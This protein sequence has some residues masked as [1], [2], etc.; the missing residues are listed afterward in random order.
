MRGR[1][2]QLPLWGPRSDRLLACA[3]LAGAA[4][5]G[6]VAPSRVAIAIAVL[7]ILGLA[8]FV[9]MQS[10]RL[11]ILLLVA[12]LPV[13][14]VVW[15]ALYPTTGPA[16]LAKDFLF[17]IPAY[18]GFFGW[19]LTTKR[20]FAVPGLPL[21]PIGLLA[22]LVLIGLLNPSLPSMPVGL[23][24]VKVWLFYIP[25]IFLGYHLIRTRGDLDRLI[26]LMCLTAILP[27]VVGVVEAVLVYTGHANTVYSL[28]GAAASTVTQQYASVDVGGGT[29][30]RVPST[31]SFVAQYYIFMTVMVGIGY[32]WW[33]SATPGSGRRL[34]RFC[35]WLL[36]IVAVM[37][38]GARGALAF[39]PL[40]LVAILV[41]EG[42]VG[43]PSLR[44]L[45]ALAAG[46]LVM[47][48]LVGAN[49]VGAVGSLLDNARSQVHTVVISGATEAAQHPLAGLGPGSDTNAAR[50]VSEQQFSLTNP[51]QESYLAKI[52]LE[53]GVGGLVLA[54]A[55]YGSILW[56]G[57]RL[58][59]RLR[60]PGLRV[61]SAAILGLMVWAIAYTVKAQYL[62]FDPL[63]V[64]YWLLTGVLFKLAVLDR[65][66][67]QEEGSP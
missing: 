21:A 5:I 36:F 57:L 31:F 23:V 42:R 24:G 19:Y 29:F 26:N 48:A 18:A 15:V 46:G 27:A 51:W 25:M 54:A 35:T 10:W 20:G 60:D 30:L 45:V 64:Y 17:V 11:S 1:A 28:Y 9:G 67:G 55:V 49:P 38:S 13:S 6:V 47:I 4:L 61:V 3:A 8:M 53:L 56:R 2:A 22:A 7:L 16:A 58:N 62:D 41:I 40:L 52:V 65:A 39:V 12:Y 32:A 37:T 33:R 14:G 43:A 44:A 50:Y 34:F 66:G 59:S 63:N